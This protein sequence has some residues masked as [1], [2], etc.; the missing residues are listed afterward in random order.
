MHIVQ[1]LFGH[2]TQL[3]PWQ[4]AAR[5][6]TI[7]I[8]L[9]IMIRLSG[10]R[11]FGQRSPFDAGTAVLLGAVLSRA[12]VGASPYG[13][14]L[15]AGLAIVVMHRAIAWTC[16]RSAAFD[17]LINGDERVLMVNGRQD[18][19]AMRKALITQRDLDEAARKKFGADQADCIDRAVLERDGQVSLSKRE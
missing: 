4:M 8:F 18:D 16:V 12:V 15:A 10:R 5:A 11:S 6:C 7:F 13:S 17:R 19:E 2:G 1:T 9:L 14:A 3:E